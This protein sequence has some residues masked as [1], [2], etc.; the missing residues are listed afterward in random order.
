[1]VWEGWRGGGWTEMM[2]RV[3]GWYIMAGEQERERTKTQ[4]THRVTCVLVRSSDAEQVGRGGRRES[5][6]NGGR[7]RVG[8]GGNNNHEVP[9]NIWLLRLR[10]IPARN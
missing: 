4:R 10:T 2:D 8:M 3:Q 9:A 6:W 7:G 1:M 5:G